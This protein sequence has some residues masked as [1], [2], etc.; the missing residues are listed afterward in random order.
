MATDRL[1]KGDS[2]L[3]TFNQGTA[4]TICASKVQNILLII[5]AQYFGFDQWV[6]SL[7]SSESLQ[8]IFGN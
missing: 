7:I 3:V 6:L 5:E 2:S 1:C 8:S 4:K